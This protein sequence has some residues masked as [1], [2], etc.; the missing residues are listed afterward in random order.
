MLAAPAGSTPTTRGRGTRLATA[1]AIPAASPPP[2]TGTTSR[3]G[4]RP[5]CSHDLQGHRALAGDDPGVVER[6]HEHG[7]V[8]GGQE[9]GGLVGVVVGVALDHDR[10][11]GAAQGGDLLPLLAGGGAGQDDPAGHAQAPA[12]VGHALA[13]VAGAGTHHAVG[14]LRVAQRGDEVVGAPQLV[15]PH[16]LEV[17]PLQPDL[18]AQQLRQP[19]VALQGGADGDVAQA[20]GGGLRRRRRSRSSVTLRIPTRR[21]PQDHGLVAGQATRV[22][23]TLQQTV[24][25][26]LDLPARLEA[27]VGRPRW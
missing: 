6:G 13:V 11:L 4:G 23:L 22:T 25:V 27:D 8:L 12:G 1:A 20:L 21:R 24:A 18:G 7:P 14:P 2:P 10:R 9:G 5:S 16:R 17:L 19:L 26:D 3:S 15:G